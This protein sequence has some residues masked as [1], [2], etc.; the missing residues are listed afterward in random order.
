MNWKVQ[1]DAVNMQHWRCTWRPWSSK[2]RDVFGGWDQSYWK[3]H[4]EAEIKQTQG[5]IW[6]QWLSW[7]GN[8]LQPCEWRCIEMHSEADIIWTME[9]A[10]WPCFYKLRNAPACHARPS[11]VIHIEAEMG[12]LRDALLVY[13]QVNIG[14]YLMIILKQVWWCALWQ[15]TTENGGVH[16]VGSLGGPTG[17]KSPRLDWF[18]H[19]RV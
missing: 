7:W 18:A 8:S 11:I 16:G 13:D 17:A 1:F 3:I 19:K 2:N 6:S 5:C 4:M 15:C 14:M 9:Y 10:C 12:K